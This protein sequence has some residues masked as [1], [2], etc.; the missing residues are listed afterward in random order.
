MS[1]SLQQANM[2]NNIF[3]YYGTMKK[4]LLILLLCISAIFAKPSKAILDKVDEVHDTVYVEQI[5]RD[6]VY[7]P[8]NSRTD[9]IY[10]K[11]EVSANESVPQKKCCA[12]TPDNPLGTD[13]TK[14]LRNDTNYTHYHL[15][16]HFDLISIP[17]LIDTTFTSVGGNIEFSLNR[18]KSIMFNLRYSKMFPK[19]GGDV[20]NDGI[21]EG[22][23]SQFDIGLGYRYYFRPSKYSFYL[24]VGGNWLIRKH[25]YTN[26]WDDRPNLYNDRPHTRHETATLFAPYLHAGHAFRG[27]RAVFGFEYGFS[28]GVSDKDLLKKEI[29]YISA[30]LQLD[31]R[32]NIGMG[33]F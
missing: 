30:G 14:Y 16:L 24:D 28:Y 5:I 15:Y 21:Y 25:D 18:K 4:W 31:L 1:E 27:T 7:I 2:K 10:V 20:F 26:T 13:T 32:L 3:I 11:K 9:T 12:P 22:Y 23:I 8:I 29:S 19:V 17:W 33:I 6:T